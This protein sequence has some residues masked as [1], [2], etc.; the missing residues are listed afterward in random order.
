MPSLWRRYLA[1]FSHNRAMSIVAGG[2]RT[3][4]FLANHKTPVNLR[5]HHVQWETCMMESMNTMPTSTTRSLPQGVQA[6]PQHARVPGVP[7][8]PVRHPVPA[9]GHSKS[10]QYF[11]PW[12]R[13]LGETDPLRS[14]GQL[15]PGYGSRHQLGHLLQV[16]NGAVGVGH[17]D[18]IFCPYPAA[19]PNLQH[20]VL[21]FRPNVRD[22]ILF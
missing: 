15:L 21:F 1:V 19:R 13:R 10:A 3:G 9:A 18:F 14:H 2:K 5:L 4:V 6:C 8:L 17:Y 12:Q 11:S 7:R 16:E 20:S 22:L